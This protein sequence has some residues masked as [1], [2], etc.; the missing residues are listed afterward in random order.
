M[1]GRFCRLEPLVARP[2]C[3]LALRRERAR[4][5]GAHVDLPV[6]GPYRARRRVSR[7]VAEVRGA[8]S[9][10]LFF[11]IVDCASRARRRVSARTCASN[12]PTESIEVGHLAFSPLLQRTAGGD[13]GDVSDDAAGLRARLP[14]LRMEVRRAQR[15]L[16]PRGRAAR[17]HVRRHLPP[18]R[19]STRAATAT[20]P[21]TRSSTANGQ[22]W[23]RRSSAGS[24]RITSIRKACSAPRFRM[25][26]RIRAGTPKGRRRIGNQAR[27]AAA[28]CAT[29]G[30][31]RWLRR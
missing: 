14:A 17:I 28:V 18:G 29:A 6:R 4:P 5:R 8:A 22:R 21:G 1:Q 12:P 15:R 26:R 16:A 2:S 11:A 30:S 24:R 23:T 31:A 3:G 20:P 19:S 7:D 9:D 25:V 13:R 27:Y 10:P